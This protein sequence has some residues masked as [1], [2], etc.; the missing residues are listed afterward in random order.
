MDSK[1]SGTTLL[2]VGGL[3]VLGIGGY[4]FYNY[5]TQQQAADRKAAS[6]QASLQARQAQQL[7]AA[8]KTQT[9][10]PGT[11]S[12]GGMTDAQIAA[13]AVAA[14]QAAASIASAV[15]NFF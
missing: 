3:A 11:S 9:Y 13:T 7:A 2:I 1:V 12:G 8:Q 6:L 4:L 14:A 5:E 10:N 15:S